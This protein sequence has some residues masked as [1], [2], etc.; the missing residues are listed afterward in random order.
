M[1]GKRR[2]NLKERNLIEERDQM[3]KII[4]LTKINLMLRRL[5][6][7]RVQDL[8]RK[9]ISNQ[10]PNLKKVK[11]DLSVMKTLTVKRLWTVKGK[12]KRERGMQEHLLAPQQTQTGI[13]CQEWMQSKSGQISSRKTSSLLLILCKRLHLL[14]LS[15]DGLLS[16]LRNQ[17][18]KE[19]MSWSIVKA[20]LRQM[21]R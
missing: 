1:R 20:F 19:S 12:R 6:D 8:K 11:R 16:N 2:L 9:S 18:T 5:I 15:T 3:V 4:M 14:N 17:R 7:V 10:Q 21:S 13:E